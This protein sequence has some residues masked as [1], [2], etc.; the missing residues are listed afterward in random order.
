MP[1]PSASPKRLAG[2]PQPGEHAGLAAAGARGVVGDAVRQHGQRED[3]LAGVPAADHA[4]RPGRRRTA[5]APARAAGRARR[6]RRA[7]TPAISERSL[8]SRAPTRLHSGITSRAG[9]T[10]AGEQEASRR[11]PAPARGRRSTARRRASCRCRRPGS[12]NRPAAPGT[13]RSPAATR[14]WRAA[15]ARFARPAHRDCAV[16][17]PRKTPERAHHDQRADEHARPSVAGQAAA[18]LLDDQRGERAGDQDG[19]RQ[20]RD[21]PGHQPGA[22]ARSRRSSRPASPRR[23]PGRRRTRSRWPGT[24]PRRRR[25]RRRRCRTG[26]RT[27]PR[28]AR[29]SARPATS[30]NGRR[31]PRAVGEPAGHRVD[32]HVPGLRQQHEQPGDAGG[33]AERVGQVGQK[34]QTG[35]GAERAGD[36]RT[37]RIASPHAAWQRDAPAY[38][39][40][41]TSGRHGRG[42]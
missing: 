39:V 30:R 18:G 2:R 34:E 5:A 29:A 13:A 26:R 6:R 10:N 22:L 36:Q 9:P 41:G 37:E 11:L 19:Q 1:G 14:S 25:R 28:T 4:R 3:L 8:P 33:D 40:G 35:H 20:H 23:A 7:A 16:R 42:C 12:R 17:V 32:Q 21:P 31:S 27:S 15:T 38:V 24:R